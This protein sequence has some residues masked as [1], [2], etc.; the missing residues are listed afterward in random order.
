LIELGAQMCSKKAKCP[1]CPLKKSCK[2]YSK[3]LV[4]KLPFKSKKISYETIVRS[5]FLIENEGLWLVRQVP[6]GEV[7]EGLWEFPYVEGDDPKKFQIKLQA[8]EP[9][10]EESHSFTRY[11]CRLHPYLAHCKNCDIDG[12]QWLSAAKLR[13]FP[14]SSGHKKLLAHVL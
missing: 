1:S 4:E 7:M 12:Y 5:V 9:L 10:K 13:A 11:R 14:F 8:L 3:K 2:A 6:K